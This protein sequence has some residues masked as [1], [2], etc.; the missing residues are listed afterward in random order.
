M[1]DEMKKNIDNEE[2]DLDQLKDITGG[3]SDQLTDSSQQ[4]DSQ[5][6]SSNYPSIKDRLNRID[7]R[8]RRINK[9]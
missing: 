2:I 5:D 3:T 9:P 6:Y 1:A 7:N 8:L 4:T